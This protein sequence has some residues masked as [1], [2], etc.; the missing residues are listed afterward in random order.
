MGDSELLMSGPVFP[1][2]DHYSKY[3][4]QNFGCS[5]SGL[6]VDRP[7]ELCGPGNRDIGDRNSA[8][9]APMGPKGM[10]IPEVKEVPHPAVPMSG[11]KMPGIEADNKYNVVPDRV[12]A[13]AARMEMQGPVYPGVSCEN[14]YSEVHEVIHGELFHPLPL[15]GPKFVGVDDQCKYTPAIKK[16]DTEGM[17]V[18]S[19]PC[20]R[21][22]V[23]SSLYNESPARAPS[24][25]TRLMTGPIFPGIEAKNNFGPASMGF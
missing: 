24:E 18:M 12:P 20:A 22:I 7:K 1:I 9:I 19:G 17:I 25:G 13:A 5:G 21:Q 14:H 6:K 15:H 11:P 3:T 23:H 10:Y 16:A 8:L 4:T 2:P